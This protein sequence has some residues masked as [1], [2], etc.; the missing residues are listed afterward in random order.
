[1]ST[2]TS[3]SRLREK[4]MSSG[5]VMSGWKSLAL[6]APSSS[7]GVT[8][9]PATSLMVLAVRTRYVVFLLVASPS[10]IFMALRS[11]G[12]MLM[13]ISYPSGLTVEPLALSWYSFAS[14]DPSNV[15]WRVMN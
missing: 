3:S 8:G 10:L 14:S 4:A 13:T 11:S 9:E 1:M 12:C 15:F 7:M 2:R 5:L 6:R